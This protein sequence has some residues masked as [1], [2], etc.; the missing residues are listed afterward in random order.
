MAVNLIPGDARRARGPRAGLPQLGPGYIVLAVLVIAVV[1]VT[2]AV[3]TNNT[4]SSRQAQLTSVRAQLARE[5]ALANQLASYQKFAALAQARAQ[6]VRQIISGRFDWHA[7]LSD[8][9]KVVPANTT[10]Q[11]VNAS[12]SS[13][14]G[15]GAGTS[16][17]RSAIPAPAFDIT[18]CTA[19][20]DDV[21][22]LMSRLRTMNGVTRVTLQ[23]SVKG[24]QS[25]AAAT[26][27][28]TAGTAS[29][30]SGPSFHL[31]VFFEPLS[32]PTATTSPVPASTAPAGSSVT[33]TPSGTSTVRIGGTP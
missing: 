17:L 21:A 28:S 33:T 27:T 24:G 29:C 22:R 25:V 15:S 13:T 31:V 2:I 12:V 32:L 9:S 14:A 26:S 19:T 3:T 5:Q 30:A 6:T 7:A 16:S 23:S 11:S 10:L 8:L 4:I 20:Q 18:G 1:F